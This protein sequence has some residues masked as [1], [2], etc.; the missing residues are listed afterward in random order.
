[1]PLATFLHTVRTALAATEG[2]DVSRLIHLILLLAVIA[3][4]WNWGPVRERR[5]QIW[6]WLQAGTDAVSGQDS[7]DIGVE[8]KRHQV[9]NNLSRAL[10]EYRQ[11]NGQDPH[12]LRDLVTAGLL[13][14]SEFVDEWGRPLETERGTDGLRVRS[15]GRDGVLGTPDDWVL[16]R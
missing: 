2:C 12:E 16:G 13:Q 8:I 1:M 15:R 4:T 9:Q 14:S 5:V 11:L 6:G 7:V 10:R 3:A